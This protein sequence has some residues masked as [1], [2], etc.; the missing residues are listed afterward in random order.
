M[1]DNADA[2]ALCERAGRALPTDPEFHRPLADPVLRPPLMRAA[3]DIDF[4]F[5]RPCRATTVQ[6][7]QGNTVSR[8]EKALAD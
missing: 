1:G 8:L 5:M 2:V 6:G 3:R 7:V 4:D